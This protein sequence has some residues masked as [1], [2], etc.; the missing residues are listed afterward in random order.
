MNRMNA[1]VYI[2][3]FI[4]WISAVSC[5]SFEELLPM[6]SG[7]EA[8][9]TALVVREPVDVRIYTMGELHPVRTETVIA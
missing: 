1:L 8:I 3:V 9:P 6:K 2:L 7:D 5:K 4:A